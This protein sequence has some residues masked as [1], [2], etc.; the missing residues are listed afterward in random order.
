M[1]ID[2]RID[3]LTDCLIERQTGNLVDTYYE[4]RNV[5][6][7]QKD[8]KGW[9][10]DWSKP[11]KNGYDIYEL[12]LKD[13]ETVQGRIAYRIDGGVADVDIVESAP[14]NMGHN[15][16]Y[17][18]VGGHLFALACQASFEAGCDGFVAFTAKT[19]LIEHYKESLGAKVLNGQRMYIDESAAK[20]LIEKYLER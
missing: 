9:K 18:G 19:N 3:E 20:V 7:K 14:Q 12:F 16:K 11:E 1:E 5:P 10:F 15:G 8:F 6:I 4:K 13:S 2:I 17:K